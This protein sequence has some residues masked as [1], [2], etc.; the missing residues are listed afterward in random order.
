MSEAQAELSASQQECR[1][2][3]E[4]LADTE[5]QFA[6]F[7]SKNSKVGVFPMTSLQNYN[8]IIITS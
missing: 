1:E 4:R 2:V 6:T 8:D 5:D 7:S 3:R